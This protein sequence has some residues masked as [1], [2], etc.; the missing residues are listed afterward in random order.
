MTPAGAG[1]VVVG[2]G[3]AGLDGVPL[4]AREVLLDP[5][6]RVLVRTLRH[7]AAAELARRREVRSCDDCYE[8][9]TDLAAV[10][11]TI[12]TRVIEVAAGGPTVYAVP[13]SAWVG[14]RTVSL[15]LARARDAGIPVAV[16]P[17]VSF[18]DYAY[19]AVGVDPIAQGAQIVDGRDL[20]DPF[21]LHLPT[22]VTQVDTPLV[23]ADVAATLGR[24]LDD[25]TP[26]T[27]LARL[28]APDEAVTTV[29]L[30]ALTQVRPDER[31]T[32]F[33]PAQEVGWH[34]LVVTNRLLRRRCPWDREQTHHTLL[35]HL[36]E[37]A[38]ETVAA[39][40][41]LPPAAPSGAPDLGAYAEVEEELGDLLLQ[42]VFHATLAREAGAFDVEE[43]AEGIRRKL[44]R[45]HPHVFGEVVAE[46]PDE[47]L[48]NWEELKGEEKG[49]ASLMDDVPRSLPG[50][51]RADKL[52]R[53]AASV[54]FDWERAAE[55]FRVVA[56]EL[57]ELQAAGEDPERRLDEL[58]DVLFSVVNLARHLGVDPEAALARAND[59][60]VARFRALEVLAR[61]RGLDLRDAG[62]ELLEELWET[63]KRDRSPGL[64]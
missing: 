50:I 10:Y 48:A 8:S 4:R 60:F 12:V 49:R 26:V 56:G 53:R 52:Q 55:V 36:V 34:G 61:R 54:G 17:G 43:V 11:E 47:V 6:R 23:L 20:P 42:V 44:V 27:V 25:A 32:L 3:P 9:G 59:E 2:L 15:L 63:V 33:V 38:Y 40:S 41:A 5:S 21:P 1:V 39:V 62:A 24:V 13:G 29:P 28:G 58:G 45:R 7:P 14:E 16:M 57:E 51:A 35:G 30:S 46:T 19:A 31:T 18:L 64:A 37:E 22:L